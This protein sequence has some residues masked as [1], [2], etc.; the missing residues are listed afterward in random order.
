MLKAIFWDSDGVLVSTER[1]YF[2]ANRA[3][4]AKYGFE[5]SLEQFKEISLR[6]G[7]SVFELP[8]LIPPPEEMQEKIR[9][10]R[11]SLFSLLLEEAQDK[12]LL[13]GV[14]D[15]VKK[16]SSKYMMGIVTSCRKEHFRIIHAKTQILQY[17]SFVISDGDYL[18]SKPNPDPYLN[19][20]KRSGFGTDECVVVEDSERGLAAASAAGIKCFVIPDD[21]TKDGDFSKAFKVLGNISQL[22]DELAKL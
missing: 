18:R 1:L 20:L 10:E 19:A 2:E 17:F 16:L 11:N 6:Q 8:G 15:S 3:T 21:L 14:S 9:V 4:L 5:L 7:R 12:L 22:E 13:P